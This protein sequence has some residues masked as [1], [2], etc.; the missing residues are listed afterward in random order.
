M[1][2]YFCI[3]KSLERHKTQLLNKIQSQHFPT[4]LD[5]STNLQRIHLNNFLNSISF[6]LFVLVDVLF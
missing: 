4:S 2:K 3:S 5:I 1:T 6:F